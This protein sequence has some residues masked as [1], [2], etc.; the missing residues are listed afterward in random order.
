MKR[1]WMLNGYAIAINEKFDNAY[2]NMAD[3][4]LRIRKYRDAIEC[5]EKV[6]ELSI[7][8][9]AIFE[10]IG[11]CYDRLA[12]Y[13]Q[14][15]FYYKKASHMNA[16]DSR[17]HYKIACTY[18]NE[19]SWNSANQKPQYRAAYTDTPLIRPA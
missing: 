7:P 5:L 10:A 15:R 17:M 9:A 19:S 13:A 1:H 12:N 3:A 6:L 16:E 2:R 11:H 18:M 4:Y 8:E 14:A